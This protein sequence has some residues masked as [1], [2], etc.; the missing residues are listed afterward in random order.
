MTVNARHFYRER[1]CHA[2]VVTRGVALQSCAI[3]RI[4][5]KTAQ[6]GLLRVH[7]S[8]YRCTFASVRRC[9]TA[10]SAAL[11]YSFSARRWSSTVELVH[12]QSMST[13]AL[14]TPEFRW[15]TL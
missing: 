5:A 9:R 15:T 4:C 2:C 8:E 7:Q 14:V 10:R 11:V 13:S 12:A 1:G 6:S 3:R